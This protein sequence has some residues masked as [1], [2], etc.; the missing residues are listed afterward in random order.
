M[1]AQVVESHF[2]ILFLKLRSEVLTEVIHA[3]QNLIFELI[4]GTIK[5]I[6]PIYAIITLSFQNSCES[7]VSSSCSHFL[8]IRTITT[9]AKYTCIEP[10]YCN[11]FS[12]HQ[13]TARLIRLLNS[14]CDIFIDV[15]SKKS[16]KRKNRNQNQ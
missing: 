6:C 2:S 15:Y 12:I 10:R 4:R 8:F 9:T 11:K 5:I 13:L 14:N 3:L 1:C 7:A 16:P